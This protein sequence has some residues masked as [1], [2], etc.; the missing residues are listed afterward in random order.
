MSTSVRRAPGGDGLFILALVGQAGSGKST[1][2][3]ALRAEGA[4]LIEADLIGHQVTDGDPAV[5]AA[6][7]SEYGAGIYLADGTLDRKRVAARV[8]SDPE[9]RGRLDRLVHPRILT[10]I[11]ARLDRLRAEGH[12]GPVVVD[13]ALMLEWG[14]ERECDAVMA[15]LARPADQIERLMRSRG[16]SEAEARSRLSA[17]RATEAFRAAADVT[18]ENNGSEAA[19]GEAALDAMRRLMTR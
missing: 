5:R 18:I 9:A 6:L 7:E 3:R 17:Q 2:A 10:E 8:F 19:L 16:W 13:A 12:R 4:A 1:V 14:F 11:R 15:V